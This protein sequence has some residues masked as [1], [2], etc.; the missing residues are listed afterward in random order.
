[1][2]SAYGQIVRDEPVYPVALE[3]GNRLCNREKFEDYLFS[4]IE[5]IYWSFGYENISREIVND[6]LREAGIDVI[7]ASFEKKT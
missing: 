3:V 2:A 1:M 7:L 6:W 5:E 4:L